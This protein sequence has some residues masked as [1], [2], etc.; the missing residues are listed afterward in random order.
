MQFIR[1]Y[2]AMHGKTRNQAQVL[3]LIH[4][5]QRA[6]LERRIRKESPYA[7]EI[8]QMQEQLIRLYE[9]MGDMAQVQLEAK[10]LARFREIADSQANMP[11]INLLKAYVQLNGKKGV[12]DKA[13]KLVARMRKAAQSA[14]ITK[15]DK[16]AARLNQAFATLVEYTQSNSEAALHIHQAELNGLMGIL[17]GP[18]SYKKKALKAPMMR[19]L[20]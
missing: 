18:R 6:I 3:S 16:Y 8:N 4:A 12:H 17:A 15:E 14:R 9:K 10:A 1:R 20:W 13:Q 7:K 2:V 19:H 11:S 5:L